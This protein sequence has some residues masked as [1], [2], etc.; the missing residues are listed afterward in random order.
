M[1]AA[2]TDEILVH[3]GMKIIEYDLIYVPLCCCLMCGSCRNDIFI[4]CYFPEFA[5]NDGLFYD[6]TQMFFII[7]VLLMLLYP[8]YRCLGGI[9]T[10]F[11]QGVS[12]RREYD[13]GNS[14][15][16]VLNTRDDI[17]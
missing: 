15:T 7:D 1:G 2:G 6:T 10:V 9:K 4:A 14:N 8:E 12:S 11:E 5:G 3:D 16:I 13:W 17:L